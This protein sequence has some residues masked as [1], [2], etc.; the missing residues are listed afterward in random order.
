MS[1]KNKSTS[2]AEIDEIFDALKTKFHKI[3][4]EVEEINSKGIPRDPSLMVKGTS[5][6][7]K[8]KED[9]EFVA[10]HPDV[11]MAVEYVKDIIIRN[12]KN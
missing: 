6:F 4:K 10:K 7:Y 2:P 9:A 3:E 8:K 1:K 11:L 12:L 5:K